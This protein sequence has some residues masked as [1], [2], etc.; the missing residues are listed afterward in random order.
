MWR[1][2]VIFYRIICCEGCY[3][4]TVY[5]VASCDNLSWVIVWR[6]LVILNELFVVSFF[7]F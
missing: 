4:V 1:V 5:C 6:M 7:K 2:V 3:L